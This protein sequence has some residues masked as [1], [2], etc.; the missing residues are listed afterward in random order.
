MS[1]RTSGGGASDVYKVRTAIYIQSE[2][3]YARIDISCQFLP[4]A[5]WFFRVSIVWLLLHSTIPCVHI[6]SYADDED[7]SPQTWQ[8]YRH[9]RVR[10]AV[11]RP[12]CV[13]SPAG[14]SM[15]K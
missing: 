5:K 1:A 4:L 9:P 11:F 2:M 12:K 7:R 13:L 8:L 10:D 15:D 3:D 6:I 14:C